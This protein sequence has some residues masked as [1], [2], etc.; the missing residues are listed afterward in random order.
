MGAPYAAYSDLRRDGAE[1]TTRDRNAYMDLPFLMSSLI[2]SAYLSRSSGSFL[3]IF[4]DILNW[5]S[6]E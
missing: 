4:S 5:A 6:D 1:D 2:L 3:K